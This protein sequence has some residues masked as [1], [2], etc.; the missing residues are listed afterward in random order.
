MRIPFFCSL[1]V[2]TILGSIGAAQSVINAGFND[3]SGWATENDAV[4]GHPGG[5]G[6]W[7]WDTPVVD[8]T[9]VVAMETVLPTEGTGLGL[10]YAGGDFFSQDITFDNSGMYVFELDVNA[11][12]GVSEPVGLNL[13]DGE[14]EL[15]L[16]DSTSSVYVIERQN[17]WETISWGQFVEAGSHEFS[18]RNTLI[19]P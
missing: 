6:S 5:E 8:E 18:I 15:Q 16:G 7:E 1:L 2:L 17:G 11:I 19:A 12:I 9:V 3:Q 14:F 4:L 10:T 13:V